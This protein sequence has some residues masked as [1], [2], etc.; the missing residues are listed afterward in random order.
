MCVEQNLVTDAGTCVGV[1][2]NA[3]PSK[4]IAVAARALGKAKTGGS[5]TTGAQSSTPDY[6]LTIYKLLSP[7]KE[8]QSR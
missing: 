1:P 3:K 5:G 7:R 4:F 2:G 6:V 8:R